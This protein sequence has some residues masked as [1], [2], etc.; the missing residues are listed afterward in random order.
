MLFIVLTVFVGV[1]ILM[2]L[3]DGYVL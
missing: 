2:S 1:T 3:R